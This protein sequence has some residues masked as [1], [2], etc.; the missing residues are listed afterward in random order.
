MLIS[1]VYVNWLTGCAGAWQMAFRCLTPTGFISFPGFVHH[2]CCTS[3]S[4]IWHASDAKRRMGTRYV[5]IRWMVWLSFTRLLSTYLNYHRS[6]VVVQVVFDRREWNIRELVRW[7]GHL[8]LHTTEWWSD[9]RPLEDLCSLGKQLM[10]NLDKF[11]QG[12]GRL[13]WFEDGWSVS[14]LQGKDCESFC[15]GKWLR[16]LLLS[17]RM[18]NEWLIEG[19]RFRFLDMV[20]IGKKMIAKR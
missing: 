17:L 19:E 11:R 4:L 6:L 8:R 5:F 3:S 2:S 9:W 20:Q 14:L 12:K 1:V 18:P 10:W 13:M 7:C 16:D 15:V